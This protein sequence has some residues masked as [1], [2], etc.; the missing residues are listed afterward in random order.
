MTTAARV[1][2]IG[3]TIASGLQAQTGAGDLVTAARVQLRA[4]NADSGLALLR[5]AL[6][7]STPGSGTDRMNAFVWRGVLQFYKGRDSLA[8]ESFRE[9]LLIDPRL[10]VAGLAQIDSGLALEFEA[11]RRSVQP[12]ALARPSAA[13]GRLAG[14]PHSDT[15][16]SC[17]PDCRGL[18]Q[19]PRAV[20]AEARTVNLSGAGGASVMGGVA[21]VRFVVDTAGA[22]E[23]AS[24][25]VLSSPSPSLAESLINHVRQLRFAPGQ[26]QGRAV[27]VLLQWRLNLR[28]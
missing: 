17:V 1:V 12:P 15:T 26:V 5:V 22:V 7:S 8:R 14:A 18:D 10:E 2:F 25:T 3:L 11:I 27:R 6:D 16:Y 13:L 21:V 24:V 23:P 20:S 28:G 9:A 4:G 19:A